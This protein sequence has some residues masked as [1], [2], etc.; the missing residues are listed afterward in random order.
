[1]RKTNNEDSN[2][3]IR[4]DDLITVQPITKHQKEAY[5]AYRSGDHLA[6]V[7]TAGTGKTF[8]AMYLALEEVMDKGS[9]YD[10]VHIIRSVVPTRDMGFL[11]G[12]LEEKLD[13][14][15]GPYRSTASHLFQDPRAF[16]KLVHNHYVS[17]E[18]TS[19]IRGVTFDNSIVIVDEMQNLNFHELDSV[20][21]RVGECTKIIFCGDYKQSDFKNNKDREGVNKF[22]EILEHM[23]DF[24]VINFGWEDIVRSDFLR[25]YI[26]TK[27]WLES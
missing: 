9:P 24:S 25:D 16:D 3:K 14:F 23:Q 6:L 18:S 7:G 13:A 2:N 21:T 27:E 15:T 22:L 4:I 12:S 1:M 26:I 17:F 10:T 11:P 8:L 20:I 5:D 19:Y